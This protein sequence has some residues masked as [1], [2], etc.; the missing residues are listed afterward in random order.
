MHL[1]GYV[2]QMGGRDL[3]CSSILLFKVFLKQEFQKIYIAAPKRKK[4]I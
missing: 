4:L 2:A 3:C 1:F